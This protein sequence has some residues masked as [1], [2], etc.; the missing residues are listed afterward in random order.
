MIEMSRLLFALW[1]VL[2]FVPDYYTLQENVFGVSI[3]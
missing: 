1:V 2:C 3:F